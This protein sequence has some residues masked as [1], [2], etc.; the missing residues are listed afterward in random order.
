MT[1]SKMTH[2]RWTVSSDPGAMLGFLT[3]MASARKLRLLACAGCRHIADL[4]P[5]DILSTACAVA[6]R[7]A[8][9]VDSLSDL[10]RMNSLVCEYWGEHNMDGM[11]T[12]ATCAAVQHATYPDIAASIADCLD[13]CVSAKVSE[14]ARGVDSGEFPSNY[15]SLIRTRERGVMSRLI[16][17]VFRNPAQG[18]TGLQRLATSTLTSLALDI[19]EGNCFDQLPTLGRLLVDVGC[20][21]QELLEHCASPQ[22]HTRGCWALDEVLGRR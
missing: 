14:V 21:D 22:H 4:F 3:P 8:D 1:V 11:V 17:E 13:C 15:Q 2:K 16:R 7:F 5:D 19:Y 18:T 12:N 9:G 20:K 6:E 10:R